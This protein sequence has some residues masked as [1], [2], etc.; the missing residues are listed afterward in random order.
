MDRSNA[1]QRILNSKR[2]L[3]GAEDALENY[4]GQAL[5]TGCQ[6]FVLDEEA[7]YRFLSSSTLKPDGQHIVAPHTGPGRWIRESGLVGFALLEGGK[8]T[9]GV[10]GGYTYQKLVQF[11]MTP[12]ALVYVGAVP[13]VA[14]LLGACHGIPV[15]LALLQGET[16][17][18]A[19]GLGSASG[20]AILHSGDRIQLRAEGGAVSDEPGSLQVIL[21]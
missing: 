7:N 21:A 4:I 9:N 11:E 19:S 17:L 15:G 5:Q 3:R 2:T 18:I 13:R 14:Q 1:G 12:E 10:F 6:C 20:G 8:L 16:R